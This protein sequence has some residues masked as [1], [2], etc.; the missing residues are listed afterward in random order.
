[1][2][3]VLPSSKPQPHNLLCSLQF[4]L[5]L[6]SQFNLKEV[7]TSKNPTRRM[8]G[9]FFYNWIIVCTQP[10]ICAYLHAYTYWWKKSG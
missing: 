7:R 10:V 6:A 9:C 4:M 3:P 5:N 8:V 1:M 2:I